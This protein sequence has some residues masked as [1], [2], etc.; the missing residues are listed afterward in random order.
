MGGKDVVYIKQAHASNIPITEVQKMLKKE[1]DERFS[2]VDWRSSLDS[3]ATSQRDKVIF[4]L[5][6]NAIFTC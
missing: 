5:H 2:D 3:E 4:V 6:F 1:A